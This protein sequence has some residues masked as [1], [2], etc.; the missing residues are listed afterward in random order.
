MRSL[1]MAGLLGAWL[2]AISGCDSGGDLSGAPKGEEQGY[3]PLKM[4][5]KMVPKNQAIKKAAESEKTDTP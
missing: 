1:L 3:V 2:F 5:P 4:Q